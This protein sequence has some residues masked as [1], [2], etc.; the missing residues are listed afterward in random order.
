M[1]SINILLGWHCE[2]TSFWWKTFEGG[3]PA[4]ICRRPLLAS[5]IPNTSSAQEVAAIVSMLCLRCPAFDVRLFGGVHYNIPY[6]SYSKKAKKED[7]VCTTRGG[8]SSWCVMPFSMPS[9]LRISFSP[10]PPSL[11]CY[12]RCSSGGVIALGKSIRIFAGER[13]RLRAQPVDHPHHIAS[14]HAPYRQEALG[15]R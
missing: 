13:R 10:H 11:H 12:R 1:Q 3:C 15:L 14:R 9:L 4:C 7:F 5:R 6:A 2:R 8:I